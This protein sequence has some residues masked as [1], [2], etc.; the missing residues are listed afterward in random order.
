MRGG[1]IRF[2]FLQRLFLQKGG[3]FCSWFLG[4]AGSDESFF[5]VVLFSFFSTATFGISPF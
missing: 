3:F 2:V 4:G 1:G 5:F